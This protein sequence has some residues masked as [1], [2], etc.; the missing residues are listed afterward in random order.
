VRKYE[1]SAMVELALRKLKSEGVFSTQKLYSYK[2]IGFRP[3]LRHFES[4]G[5]LIVNDDMLKS[6][7]ED[8]HGIYKDDKKQAWRWHII[9]RSTELLMYFVATGRVDLP[10]MPKW[11][12]R[13][14]LFY[15]EPTS[16]QLANNDNIYGLVWRTR[17]AFSTFGYAERTIMY[18]NQSGF[19]KLLDA[20][21]EARTE[22][23]SRKLCAQVV[24]DTKKRVDDGTLHRYQAIR[25][26]AALL[27]EVHQYGSITPARLSPFDIS[28]LN[29]VFESLVDEYGNDAL[30]SGKLSEVT[31]RTAKSILKGFLL[32]LEDA[33]FSSFD[34]I[35]LSTV[36]S[37]ITQTA[38]MHYKRSAESLL[39]YVREFLKYLYEYGLIETNLS[40]AVPKMAA[41]HKKV[42]QGF[43]N[44]EIKK[45]L[46][47]VDCDTPIGKRDYAIMML[48]A[49]TGLRSG[50]ILKLKR[51]DIDWRK[52]EIHITQSKTDTAL[53]VT[54]EIESGNAICDYILNAR[55]ESEI[56]N[57]FLA[58][59]YP[60]R[61]L[62]P[63]TARGIMYK[64]MAIAGI[65]TSARQRYGFH[66]FRRAFGTRLLESGTPVH[67]LSQLL[68]HID[69]DSAK[70]Y[71]STSEKGLKE[72]CLSLAFDESEGGV[73]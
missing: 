29:P 55:Q 28:F 53:C 31:V 8:R 20:H 71:I 36:G 23:Y 35:T 46:A 33:G 67:L 9:R 56:P 26:A 57:I 69:L 2:S 22:V 15:V 11:N 49:Q 43:T 32:D 10:P 48:A 70:P 61:I 25:K 17:I 60:L 24:L 42:Y 14:C 6:Y 51:G 45:L 38:A 68:G 39:H 50:D 64:Y 30:F 13:D 1:L 63:M 4:T 40:V 47:A 18:Y 58:N 66:S 19:R 5:K 65:E 7:L 3:L 62:Q 54:L 27:H 37:V 73:L 44:D 16:E 41:P 21:R 52:R 12:K 72:C 59:N 34:G